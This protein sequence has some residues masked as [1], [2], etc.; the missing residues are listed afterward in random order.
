MGE[1]VVI[2]DLTLQEFDS[3][4][5]AFS[6][7][8]REGYGQFPKELSEYFLSH[9]YLKANF[10]NWLARGIRKILVAVE[11]GKVISFLVGDHTYGGV[12]F[13]SW[14]GVLPEYRNQGIGSR[15]LAIYEMYVIDKKGHLL[16]LYTYDGA[17]P[18]YLKHGFNEIG[19]RNPG[20]YG[21][22]NIIMNKQLNGFDPAILSK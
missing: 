2:K 8:M 14:L 19:R 10:E 13:V 20:F 22:L 21:Q 17:E 4:Y 1:E 18:F 5:D 11:D 7:L 16:E 12:G 15:M 3:F 6:V 9:D